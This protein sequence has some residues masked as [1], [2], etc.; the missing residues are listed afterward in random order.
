ML[1]YGTMGAVRKGKYW[2]LQISGSS[3]SDGNGGWI[4]DRWP[5]AIARSL[6]IRSVRLLK[7]CKNYVCYGDYYNY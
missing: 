3:S 6:L 1:F 5:E 7:L 4:G 2:E